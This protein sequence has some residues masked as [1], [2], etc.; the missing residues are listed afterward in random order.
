V[1]ARPRGLAELDDFD[2]VFTA[3]AHRSRRTILSVL[4][5]R[6]GEMTSGAIADRF[7]CSW[8]TTTQHLRVLEQAGLVTIA[9]RGRER[10]YRLQADRLRMVADG[11]LARFG[12]MPE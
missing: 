1:S 4:H 8:P 11:W 7:D 12:I 3:L 2:A 9:L 6:G 5:A 10:V